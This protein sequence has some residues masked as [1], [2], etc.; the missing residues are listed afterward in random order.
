MKNEIKKRIDRNY[1]KNNLRANLLYI[2]SSVALLM[3]VTPWYSH[4][5][6]M[7]VGMFLFQFVFTVLF[8]IAVFS[9]VSC[10]S[11]NAKKAPRYV[12][13]LSGASTAGICSFHIVDRIAAVVRYR[14]IINA[15][16]ARHLSLHIDFCI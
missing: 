14:E 11:D 1:L 2:L 9:Q 13:I 15:F 10:L 3:V 4:I 5:V 6:V 12:K 7:G 16:A 8:Q